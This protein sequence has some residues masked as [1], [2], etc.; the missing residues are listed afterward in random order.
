MNIYVVI[1]TG[2]VGYDADEQDTI[3]AVYTDIKN[4]EKHKKALET[5]DKIKGELGYCKHRID[6]FNADDNGT[7]ADVI[8]SNNKV[9]N[10]MSYIGYLD[11]A[12]TLIDRSKNISKQS[13]NETLISLGLAMSD[14]TTA[15][16][17]LGKILNDD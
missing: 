7:I 5:Q 4:A 10:E 8:S 6:S 13:K 15:A 11:N 1:T 2:Y 9:K 12:K 16:F 14:I 3:E 17:H